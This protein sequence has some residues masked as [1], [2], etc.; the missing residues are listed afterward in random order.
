MLDTI[1]LLFYYCS[2]INYIVFNYTIPWLPCWL[3]GKES[4]CTAKDMQIQ[5]LGWEDPL[6]EGIAIHS[7]ML[8]GK[9]HGQRSLAG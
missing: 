5:S 8:L 1:V 4:A 2:A 3:S 9:S 7:S 6:E